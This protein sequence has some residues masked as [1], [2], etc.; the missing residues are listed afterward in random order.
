[1]SQPSAA[2]SQDEP[3]DYTT[4]REEGPRP[5]TERSVSTA[6]RDRGVRKFT[7][8]SGGI[9]DSAVYFIDGVHSPES[10]IRSWLDIN[11]THGLSDWGLHQK[12][13][14][15]GEKFK[16]ASYEILGPFEDT[17]PDHDGGTTTMTECPLC[18]GDIEGELPA[19]IRND[20]DST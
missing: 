2:Q 14:G 4:L 19:H 9:N 6:S 16:E 8:G 10:V 11:G 1:M 20:C 5:L 13:S 15:Y 12:I 7:P 3:R 18:G 17:A